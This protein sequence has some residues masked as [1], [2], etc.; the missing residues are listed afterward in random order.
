MK[1]NNNSHAWH[2]ESNAQAPWIAVGRQR[3]ETY[4]LKKPLGRL[5]AFRSAKS[6]SLATRRWKPMK[7]LLRSSL[8]TALAALLLLPAAAQVRTYE[9]LTAQVPFKFN[10]GNRTFRPGQYQFILVGPGLLALRDAKAHIVASLITRSAETSSPSTS[11][12][13]VFDMK[14]RHARLAQISLENR[15]QVLEVLGE[16]RPMPSSPTVTPPLPVDGFFFSNR[17]DVPRLKQ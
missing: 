14:E 8:F 5:A 4:L 11:T 2:R 16:Q 9:V 17:S 1:T 7:F 3:S 13:L 10:V 15:S 12:K 6:E